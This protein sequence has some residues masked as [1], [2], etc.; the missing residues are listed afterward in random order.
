MIVVDTNVIVRLVVGGD[1]G[2]ASTAL[3]E[4]DAEFV[5]LARNLGVPHPPPPFTLS[6]P[7]SP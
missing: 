1:D 3:L 4:H 2:A 6:P 5:V 7:H